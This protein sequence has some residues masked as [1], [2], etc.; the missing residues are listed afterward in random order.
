MKIRFDHQIPVT[1][2]DSLVTCEV[3]RQLYFNPILAWQEEGV[4][5]AA[6]R[7]T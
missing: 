2:R 3:T 7:R 6:G 4:P 1:A 5:M